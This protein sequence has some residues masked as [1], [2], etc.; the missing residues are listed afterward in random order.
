MKVGNRVEVRGRNG[1]YRIIS[2]AGN[3]VHLEGIPNEEPR[4]DQLDR[5]F[6]TTKNPTF[7]MDTYGKDWTTNILVI[8]EK[9]RIRCK[10]SGE[11]P[12][13][14][15]IDKKVLNKAKLAI[16]RFYGLSEE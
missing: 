7:L 13:K 2:I 15:Y 8:L 5:L 12:T 9:A 4:F 1:V 3:T 6:L 11:N 10:T 14:F 16:R